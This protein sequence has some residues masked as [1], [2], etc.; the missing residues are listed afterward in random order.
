MLLQ[1]VQA[2]LI[3]PT[4]Q[5][6]KTAGWGSPALALPVSTSWRCE[7]AT[8]SSVGSRRCVSALASGGTFLGAHT[9]CIQSHMAVALHCVLLAG[10]AAGVEGGITQEQLLANFRDDVWS[11]TCVMLLR[12]ITSAEIKRRADH[13]EPFVLVSGQQ[14]RG[15]G[16]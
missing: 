13:F 2:I 7:P 5:A 3:A 12:F 8:S 16:V 1:Q 15:A 4:G 9:L 11:N 14:L 6:H 10:V